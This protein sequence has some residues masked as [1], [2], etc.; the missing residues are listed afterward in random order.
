MAKARKKSEQKQEAT[1][2]SITR[3]SGTENSTS[4]IIFPALSPKIDLE[5][6]VALED[7]I[8]LLDV[9]ILYT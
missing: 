7:H 5:Y 9:S 1:S 8:I 3:P 4:T 6:K 2:T